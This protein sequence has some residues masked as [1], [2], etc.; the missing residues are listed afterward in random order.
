M[1]GGTTP[2]SYTI[3]V[4]HLFTLAMSS[5]ICVVFPFKI[6]LSGYLMGPKC[7]KEFVLDNLTTC[8]KGNN[9]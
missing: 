8:R 3:K 6:K 5:L 1:G 7:S 9:S 2:D 4:I